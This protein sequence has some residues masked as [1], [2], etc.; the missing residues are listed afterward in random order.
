MNVMINGKPANKNGLF[1][2]HFVHCEGG[3][4]EQ[5]KAAGLT[6]EVHLRAKVEEGQGYNG[7]HETAVKMGWN[8]VYPTP[9]KGAVAF[10]EIERR[11]RFQSVRPETISFFLS[12]E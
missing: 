11:G 6:G 9:K 3:L 12:Q 4:V 8:V 5:L 2:H 10:L 7:G 1:H